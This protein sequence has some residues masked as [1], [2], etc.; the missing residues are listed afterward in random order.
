MWEL[1]QPDQQFGKLGNRGSFL[2][3]PNL[4]WYLIGYHACLIKPAVSTG[5]AK[6]N[7]SACPVSK[8]V[9]LPN[10]QR[11]LPALHTCCPHTLRIWKWF[12]ALI[13]LHSY[14][15]VT[16]LEVTLLPGSHTQGSGY[17]H[18][19]KWIEPSAPHQQAALPPS[20]LLTFLYRNIRIW[21]EVIRTKCWGLRNKD[22]GWMDFQN[23]MNHL[24][25]H[26]NEKL[27]THTHIHTHTHCV[28]YWD[29]CP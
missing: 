9:F 15:P 21:N 26:E 8:G 2:T 20:S 3:W 27:N 29:M 25:L 24:T 6:V 16:L 23:F 13:N 4:L 10:W 11:T 12:I 5:L 28:L 14:I 7:T 1:C 19:I 18:I 22:Y 17:R